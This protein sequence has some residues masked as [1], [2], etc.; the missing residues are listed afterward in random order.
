[1]TRTFRDAL[2]RALTDSGTS[3]ANVA[4]GAQVSYEQLKKVA[5]REGASTN[6]DDAVKVARHFGLS[7]DEFLADEIP[8]MRD[9]MLLLLWQ[10]PEAEREFLLAFAR[11]RVALGS[12]KD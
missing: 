6:V 2:L 10:L 3:L 12:R 5:Q 8:G 11:Q 4:R 9:E 7:L 1:M